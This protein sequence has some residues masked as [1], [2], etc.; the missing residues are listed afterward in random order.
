MIMKKSLFLFFVL[1]FSSVLSAETLHY[2]IEGKKV[3][4]TEDFS[5]YSFIRTK[6]TKANFVLPQSVKVLKNHKNIS[7]I[8]T[9]DSSAKEYLVKNGSL[10]P[11]YIKDGVKVHVSGRIFVKIPVRPNAL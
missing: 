10:F 5:S 2:Y 11:A 3:E 4:L 1:I 7:I 8:E 6:L 9:A